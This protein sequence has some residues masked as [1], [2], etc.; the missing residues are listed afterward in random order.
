MKKRRDRAWLEKQRAKG[1]SGKQIAQLAGCS[2][3]TAY[4][5]LKKFSICCKKGVK[6][7]NYGDDRWIDKLKELERCANEELCAG[8]LWEDELV[9]SLGVEDMATEYRWQNYLPV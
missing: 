3:R 9:E 8:I 2:H 5:W 1:L 7:I 6:R 4:H